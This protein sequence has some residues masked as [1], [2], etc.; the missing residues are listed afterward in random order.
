M[1]FASAIS[2]SSNETERK[3][4]MGLLK[5]HRNQLYSRMYVFTMIPTGGVGVLV[6]VC[7][8]GGCPT[9]GGLPYYGQTPCVGLQD[10]Y[11]ACT[12]TSP[13]CVLISYG[14]PN[15]KYIDKFY[16]IQCIV[17]SSG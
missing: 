6:C 5:N 4:L 2:S 13:I 10:L 16:N 9:V 8:G 7:V 17:R 3:T 14:C 11:T 15:F 12:D 1:C